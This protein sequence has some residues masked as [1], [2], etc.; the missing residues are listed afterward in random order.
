MRAIGRAALVLIASTITHGC[1]DP[2]EVW[3]PDWHPARADAAAPA[4][5]FR[6]T[7]LV[8]AAP[9]EPAQPGVVPPNAGS[10]EHAHHHDHAPE[11]EA[12]AAYV[13]PMHPDVKSNKPDECPKCGMDLVNEAPGGG[14]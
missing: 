1:A 12:E 13:C 2:V 3:P 4:T 8:G 10:N 5:P 7:A 11:H 9:V 14:K 6:G